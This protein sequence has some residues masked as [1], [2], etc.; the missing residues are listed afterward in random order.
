MTIQ[1][2]ETNQLRWQTDLSMLLQP[3]Q[4]QIV[5]LNWLVA[6]LEYFFLDERLPQSIEGLVA[7]E[8]DSYDIISGKE[9]Y[10]SID[11][12]DIQVVWGVFCGVVGDVPNLQEDKIP[13]ADGNKQLWAEPEAFQ[14]QAS[15]IEIVCVDSSLTLIKFRDEELGNQFLE[16]FT[17]GQIIKNPVSKG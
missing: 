3:L 6:D 9:L 5:S 11:N 12:R 15:E 7:D 1:L 14:L 16:T 4:Q 2:A 10:N 13:Y 8:H 17:D